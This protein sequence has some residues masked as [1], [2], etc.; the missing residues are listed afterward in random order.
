[1][2]PYERL[3][4][5]VFLRS[6]CTISNARANSSSRRL[7]IS[8]YSGVRSLAKGANQPQE[9]TCRPFRSSPLGHFSAGPPE[10]TNS[11]APARRERTRGR[12]KTF[13]VASDVV[14][15]IPS[16]GFT[17]TGSSNNGLAVDAGQNVSVMG[18]IASGNVAT[19]FAVFSGTHHRIIGNVVLGGANAFIIFGS[20]DEVRDNVVQSAVFGYWL[21]GSDH[22]FKD[23]AALSNGT[24][25]LVRGHWP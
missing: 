25:F 15:G 23:N 24:G 6:I 19:G 20:G 17:L 18:N 22:L 14:F 3:H 1:M 2:L 13:L 11:P 8:T 21:R 12:A 16:N 9:A 4:G 7:P 5:E 10:I